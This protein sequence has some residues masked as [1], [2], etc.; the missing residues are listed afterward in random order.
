LNRYLKGK[1]IS[2]AVA[3]NLRKIGIDMEIIPLEWSVFLAKRRKKELEA[4]YYHGFSSAFEP[5]L[6]LGVLRPTLFANLTAWKNLEY[7]EGYKRMRYTFDLGERKALS[8]RLQR[9][10][11][12]EAP[13]VFLWAQKDFYGLNDRIRWIP[14]P[15][16][17]IYLPSVEFKETK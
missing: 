16:E 10:I 14:R 3:A 8:F 1:E 7:I 6:D 9:I 17:R 12:E 15:D 4:L 13:W 11:H 2:E 5:E